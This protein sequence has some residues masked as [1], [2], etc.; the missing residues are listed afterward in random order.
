MFSCCASEIDSAFDFI[1]NKI[2]NEE[3]RGCIYVVKKMSKFN[4]WEKMCNV[5]GAGLWI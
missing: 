4:S 5:K 2:K 1:K 3:R